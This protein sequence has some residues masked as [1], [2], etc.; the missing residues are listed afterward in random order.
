MNR[1]RQTA[2]AWLDAQTD[3]PKEWVSEWKAIKPSP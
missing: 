3:L 2:E 1:D